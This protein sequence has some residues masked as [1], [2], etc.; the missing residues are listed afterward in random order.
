MTTSSSAATTTPLRSPV[1][2]VDDVVKVKNR[3]P[4]TDAL[5]QTVVDDGW[6]SGL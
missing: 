3:V 2:Q 5:G 6:V 4:F 1:S